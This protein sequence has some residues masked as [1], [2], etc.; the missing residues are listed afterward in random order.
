VRPAAPLMLGLA[1]AGMHYTAMAA[2]R[3][4]V[5]PGA[6]PDHGGLE[7]PPVGMAVGILVIVVLITG[8]ALVAVRIDEWL[9]ATAAVLQD[10]RA[11]ERTLLESM[12]EGVLSVDGGAVIESANSAAKRMFGLDGQIEG[13]PLD[14]LLPQVL[15]LAGGHA[16]GRPPNNGLFDAKCVETMAR[17][18][19]GAEFPVEF[20]ASA[21][22]AD[23]QRFFSIIIRDVSQRK[24]AEQQLRQSQKLESIGQLAAGI[25]HEINTPTQYLSDN[26]R[27]LRDSFGQ[28]AGLLQLQQ[29][30]IGEASSRA[31]APEEGERHQSACADADLDFL[32]EE[33]PRSI[34]ESL[35]GLDRIASIVRSLKEFSHPDGDEMSSADL[36]RAIA[37]TITVA[38]NEWKYV[39]EVETDFDPGLPPVKCRL[40][41]LNQVF[42]NLIINAAQAIGGAGEALGRKGVIRVRTSY[43]DDWVEV[44]VEDNGPGIPAQIRDRIFDPFFTTKDVGTGTG[45][46]LAI[47]HSIIGSKHGGTIRVESEP[48]QGA[49]F[50]VRLPLDGARVPV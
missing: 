27:F 22:D 31:L 21:Y 11:R 1:V 18:D 17:R 29:R 13:R 34:E 25:A 12:V 44:R 33:T 41:D 26:V 39:A 8:C 30:L 28:L 47:A 16:G 19:D 9:R 38:R 49:A 15:D 43:E 37:S 3:F 35:E 5:R 40:G 45:Q 48:G 32:L 36:N 10:A 42:L 23:G 7:L 50:I 2:S 14:T 20:S 4:H 46:G 24:Q 6:A